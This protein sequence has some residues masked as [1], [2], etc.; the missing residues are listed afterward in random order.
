M[1]RFRILLTLLLCLTVPVAGWASV[2]AG[3]ACAATPPEA[4]HAHANGHERASAAHM[5]ASAT[6]GT[7]LSMVAHHHHQDDCADEPASGPPCKGD[8][9]GCGCGMGACSSGVFLQVASNPSLPILL[10]RAL[11]A[12]SQDVAFA[13]AGGGTLLRPPIA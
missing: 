5:H 6:Q 1:R 7:G 4:S 10:Q 8:H 9:C 13:D 12:A 3:L 2:F 11:A